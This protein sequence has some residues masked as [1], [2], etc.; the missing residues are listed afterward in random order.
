MIEDKMNHIGK[1]V[2]D[3]FKMYFEME[4]NESN[5]KVEHIH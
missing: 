3:T 4:R 2:Q 5:E 1:L